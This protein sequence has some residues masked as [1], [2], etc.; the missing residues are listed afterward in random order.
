VTAWGNNLDDEDYG[1]FA[2]GGEYGLRVFQGLPRTY[3]VTL[4]YAF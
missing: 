4:D 1:T 3:G 2:L